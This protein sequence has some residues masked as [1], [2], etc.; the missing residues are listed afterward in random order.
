[1]GLYDEVP[2][3]FAGNVHQGMQRTAEMAPGLYRSYL[4]DQGIKQQN[5]DAAYQSPARPANTHEQGIG[6]YVQKLMGD[7]P[8]EFKQRLMQELGGASQPQ[9]QQGLQAPAESMP[10]NPYTGPMA[11]PPEQYEPP[12]RMEQ[13]GQGRTEDMD[14]LMTGVSEPRGLGASMP[15][16]LPQRQPPAMTHGDVQKY[17]S[18]APMMNAEARLNKAPATPRDYLGEIA[19]R[20]ILKGEEDRKTVDAKQTGTMAKQDDQQDWKTKEEELNRAH[21]WRIATLKNEA[22][23]ASIEARI[24]TGVTNAWEIAQLRSDTQIIASAMGAQSRELSSIPNLAKDKDLLTHNAEMEKRVKQAQINIEKLKAKGPAN[25]P[26]GSASTRQTNKASSTNNV[27]GN[28][29]PVVN[30]N[31]QSG[32]V[33]ADKVEAWLKANPKRRKR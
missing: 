9:P 5:I 14:I 6:S 18:M 31:G 30:E 26:T 1:M 19:L 29:V 13:P 4:Q 3:S 27:P 28:K 17:M 10:Q 2:Q 15:Q 8:P 25:Q 20:A 22:A 24:R 32:M 21:E 11:R 7:G 16:R 12:Q 23:M 33:A